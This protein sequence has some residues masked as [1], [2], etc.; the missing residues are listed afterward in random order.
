[1]PWGAVIVFVVYFNYFKYMYIRNLPT[2]IFVTYSKQ[3][4]L[5]YFYLNNKLVGK[6]DVPHSFFNY[7]EE[8]KAYIGSSKGSEGFFKGTYSL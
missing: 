6:I 1:M 7:N 5:I 2:K 8:S 3:Q 4:Q